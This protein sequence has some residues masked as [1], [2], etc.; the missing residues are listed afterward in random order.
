MEM[1]T[2]LKKIPGFRGS[3][4]LICQP[5]MPLPGAFAAQAAGKENNGPIWQ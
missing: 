5:R 2:R 1:S 4:T 3:V